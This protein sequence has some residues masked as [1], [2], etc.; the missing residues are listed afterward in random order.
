MIKMLKYP[1]FIIIVCSLWLAVNDITASGSALLAASVSKSAQAGSIRI[2]SHYSVKKSFDLRKSR[3]VSPYKGCFFFRR[4]SF[5]DDYLPL[6]EYCRITL[7][8][9]LNSVI[10]PLEDH[11]VF[12]DAAEKLKS[13]ASFKRGITSKGKYLKSGIGFADEPEMIRFRFI[14]KDRHQ[15]YY[16]VTISGV[17]GDRVNF[18]YFAL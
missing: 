10:Y 18:E 13:D 9:V 4:T 11:D 5:S 15:N 3:L 6:H 12:S 2:I 14:V 7:V 17:F 1:F 16:A 8:P